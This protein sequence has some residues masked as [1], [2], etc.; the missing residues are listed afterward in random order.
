VLSAN[1]IGKS[2]SAIEFGHVRYSQERANVV[3]LQ[4][5]ALHSDANEGFDPESG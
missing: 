1:F 2:S 5:G 3:W 4:T